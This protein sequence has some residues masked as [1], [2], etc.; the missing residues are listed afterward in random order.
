[1]FNPSLDVDSTWLPVK[2]YIE[3]EMKVRTNKEEIYFNH[4][5]PES[6]TNIIDTQHKLI[7]LHEEARP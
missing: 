3:K 1:M 6:L 5:S 7:D 4:Y 2:H